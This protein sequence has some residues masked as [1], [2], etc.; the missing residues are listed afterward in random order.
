M[1][2]TSDVSGFF[3]VRLQLFAQLQA[4]DTDGDL[5]SFNSS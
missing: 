5:G 1:E 4:L 3:H 2:V